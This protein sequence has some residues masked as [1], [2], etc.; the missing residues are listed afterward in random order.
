MKKVI[1]TIFVLFFFTGLIL[2][3]GEQET[4]QTPV[5]KDVAGFWYAS[6]EFKGSYNQM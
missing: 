2:F 3:P 4:E 6:M 1:F 5:V